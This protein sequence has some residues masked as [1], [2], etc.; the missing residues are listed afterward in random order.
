MIVSK[1]YVIQI[2]DVP[3]GGEMTVLTSFGRIYMR[4]RGNEGWNWMRIDGPIQ[5][6][7]EY[8]R[9]LPNDDTVYSEED[10]ND[11]PQ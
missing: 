8:L 5:G 9:S 6:R 11:N 4:T 3:N 1:E 2:A 7:E 10:L